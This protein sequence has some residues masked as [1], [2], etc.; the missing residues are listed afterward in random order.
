VLRFSPLALFLQE[1]E[2]V[3]KQVNAESA[4]NQKRPKTTKSL[5]T[6]FA[7]MDHSCTD[8]QAFLKGSE[9]QVCRANK[10]TQESLYKCE[11]ERER[12]RER[13]MVGGGISGEREGASNKQPKRQKSRPGFA[14]HHHHSTA[15]GFCAY[16]MYWWRLL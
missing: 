1:E 14:H 15:S 5:T 3:I 6:L 13:E 10:A 4:L 9:R 8:E 12:E 7:S 16:L 2:E 11:R